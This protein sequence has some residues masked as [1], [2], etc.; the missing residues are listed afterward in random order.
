ML[1][2]PSSAF[3]EKPSLVASSSGSA[4]NALYARLL[5]STRKRSHSRAGASSTCSSAPVS[6]F[7]TGQR[8]R[9]RV[10]A[11]L[12]IHAF[13]EDFRGDA[14]RLL[15]ARHARERA[16]ERLLPE[17]DDYAAQV[18]TGDGFVATRGGDV[19]AYLVAEVDGGHAAVGVAGCAASEPEAVR[20]LYAAAAGGW[21]PRHQA[22]G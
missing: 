12:E 4:K 15:G 10:V 16:A 18:P 14:G 2:K 11:R 7:G 19:V 20:D 13:T 5:P 3:V 9:Q 1:V 21:P 22:P 8:Y 17:R 6:V